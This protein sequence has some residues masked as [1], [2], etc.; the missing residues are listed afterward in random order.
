MAARKRSTP[1]SSTGPERIGGIRTLHGVQVGVGQGFT[2]EMLIW[3]SED[4]AIVGTHMT[5]PGQALEEAAESLHETTEEPAEG[6]PRAPARV[7]VDS[8]ELAETLRSAL[9][10]I[11]F[12]HAP[13]PEIDG[14]I[15]DL[16]EHLGAG[17]PEFPGYLSAGASANEMAGLFDAGVAFLR[18]R[19]WDVLP[20][21]E[22]LIGFSCAK[23]A[24][25]DLAISVLG[26]GGEIRGLA[27]FD[28][29]AAFEEFLDSIE[30]H[31]K[32]GDGP[33]APHIALHFD[34]IDDLPQSAVEE[35]SK[36]GWNDRSDE[37]PWVS[38]FTETGESRGASSAQTRLLELI[39][40]AVTHLAAEPKA[41]AQGLRAGGEDYVRELELPCADDADSIAV[42]I[43]VPHPGLR[44]VEQADFEGTLA[45]LAELRGPDFDPDSARAIADKLLAE[46]QGSPEA[47]S[48]PDGG[49]AEL[50]MDFVTYFCGTT[51][52]DLEPMMLREFLFEWTPRK[53]AMPAAAAGPFVG[54]L[55]AFLTFLARVHDFEAARACRAMIGEDT[56]AILRDALNDP[57]GFGMGKSMLMMAPGLESEPFAGLM[58]ARGKK[59]STKKKAS[60]KKSAKKKSGKKKSGK[61]KPG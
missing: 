3:I 45:E 40:R 14:A 61:K 49:S 15:A 18:A 60:K 10:L 46:Y 24:A 51:V 13:T 12:R 1:T 17:G 36:H 35:I 55:E 4:G 21:D 8:A 20:D 33:I 54:E 48:A 31:Q 47:D 41:L 29:V 39:T 32:E 23:L 58:G 19:P 42:E 37:S 38:V 28:G 43:R 16:L 50:L 9:P 52:V 26:A 11:E 59:K 27:V 30:R 22:S 5:S 6:K 34:R 53:V 25:S 44:Y 56:L 2:P 57:E 7:R